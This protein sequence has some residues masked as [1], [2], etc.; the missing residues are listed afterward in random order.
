M[1]RAEQARKQAEA[2]VK[3]RT[4]A[5]AGRSQASTR[6]TRSTPRRSAADPAWIEPLV[7]RAAWPTG[8]LAWS[9]SIRSPPSPGST[10]ASSSPSRPWRS[11]REPRRASSSG[12]TL[13]YWSWLLTLEQDPSGRQ[14]AQGRADRTSRPRSSCIRPG[15]R[16]GDPEPPLQPDRPARP[17][18]SS[19]R[20]RAY[21]ADA[22]LTNADLSFSGC[23]WPRTIW[24]SSSTRHTGATRGSS[25][26]PA[27]SSS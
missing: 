11:A 1:Q 12:A 27:T 2:L 8:G 9:G 7:G 20:Q 5:R 24:G 22:Y 14:A 15:G 16:L 18:R 10:R 26:F 25:G 21:E 6:P 4:P 13:R 23:S 3:R 19:R 17:T